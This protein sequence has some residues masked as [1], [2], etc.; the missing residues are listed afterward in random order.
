MK[1][2]KGK[3]FQKFKDGFS[4]QTEN[5]RWYLVRV[6]KVY[7]AYRY[8]PHA[9]VPHAMGTGRTWIDA[10]YNTQVTVKGKVKR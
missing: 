1:R 7:C 2:K 4:I 8:Q 9:S 6:R 5:Q 10:V 3:G